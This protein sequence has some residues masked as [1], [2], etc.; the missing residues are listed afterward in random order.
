MLMQL[1]P[2]GPLF[3]S[4]P[5]SLLHLSHP[6]QCSPLGYRALALS[7]FFLLMS[8]TSDDWPLSAASVDLCP[9]KGGSRNTAVDSERV[10]FYQGSNIQLFLLPSP[11]LA[12][13]QG[14]A[15]AVQWALIG[16]DQLEWQFIYDKCAHWHMLE[17]DS[18][19]LIHVK[20]YFGNSDGVRLASSWTSLPLGWKN[21]PGSALGCSVFNLKCGY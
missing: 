21:W 14:Q 8:D 16:A 10:S 4:D 15:A 3:I 20:P 13:R 17:R 11:H 18:S 1:T 5:G 19:K 7:A 2:T 6:H 9:F 12:W